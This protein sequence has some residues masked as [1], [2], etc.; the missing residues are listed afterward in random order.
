MAVKL[1]SNLFV[2]LFLTFDTESEFE[3][4]K[5]THIPCVFCKDLEKINSVVTTRFCLSRNQILSS[6][7][8][9]LK[10]TALLIQTRPSLVNSSLNLLIGVIRSP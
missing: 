1:K 7:H 3:S 8:I 2:G 6:W 9:Q 4:T 10:L 5:D